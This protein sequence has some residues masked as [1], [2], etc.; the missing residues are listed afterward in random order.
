VEA[1]VQIEDGRTSRKEYIGE[2]DGISDK[3][4]AGEEAEDHETKEE[5]DDDDDD[6]DENEEEGDDAENDDEDDD[7]VE[8]SEGIKLKD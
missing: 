2:A 6:D 1:V 5:G 8:E 3:N 7:K 4:G